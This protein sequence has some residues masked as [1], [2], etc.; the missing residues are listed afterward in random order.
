MSGTSSSTTRSPTTFPTRPSSNVTN[1]IRIAF[2]AGK[3]TAASLHRSLRCM[4]LRDRTQPAASAPWEFADQAVG[5]ACQ[6]CTVP[7]SVHTMSD[8]TL[9][10]PAAPALPDGAVP[11]VQPAGTGRA[12]L[13]LGQ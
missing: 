11:Y 2:R 4:Q 13:L 10:S 12:H 7:V 9:A 1:F 5:R 6:A 3:Q 8:P